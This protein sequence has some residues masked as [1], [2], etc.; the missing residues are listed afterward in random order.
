MMENEVFL[1]DDGNPI[2]ENTK[3]KSAADIEA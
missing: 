3:P 2:D 1:D